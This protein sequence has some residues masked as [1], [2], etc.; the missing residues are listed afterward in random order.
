MYSALPPPHLIIAHKDRDD[1]VRN[2]PVAIE[3]KRKKRR[4]DIRE[5]KEGIK[6]PN[7][8]GIQT[9]V[10][11]GCDAAIELIKSIT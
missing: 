11:K 3:M 1:E 2:K 5:P 4:R 6:T 10:C 8:A 7:E 9:V